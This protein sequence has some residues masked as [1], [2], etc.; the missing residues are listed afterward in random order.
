MWG[1]L[2]SG[3]KQRKCNETKAE[4]SAKEAEQ[5]ATTTKQAAGVCVWEGVHGV[6]V[7]VWPANNAKYNI[8]KNCVAVIDLSPRN[9]AEGEGKES[10]SVSIS[11]SV[12]ET[13]ALI[14]C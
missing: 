4:A 7:C 1:K 2:Q 13:H 8:T 9:F 6:C 3:Q 10:S 14:Y 11:V 12:S 5:A